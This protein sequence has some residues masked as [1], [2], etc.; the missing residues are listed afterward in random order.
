[1]SEPIDNFEHDDTDIQQDERASL[2]ARANLLGIK[3][4]PS[5][6]L[7]KLRERVNEVIRGN[8]PT[9]RPNPKE[10]IGAK[11]SRLKREATKLI[12]CR[13]HC[14]DPA[15][16]DWPGEVITVSNSVVG[17]I[18][19]YIPYNQDEPYHIPSILINAMRDKKCQVFVKKKDKHNN[20][21]TETK[22]ISAYTLDIL[23]PLTAEELKALSQA[24]L[25]RNSID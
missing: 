5:L 17:T 24:Q 2:E 6:S 16:K 13:I 14:N 23:P 25:A 22:L 12:R 19:K 20:Q 18:K 10:D 1:M 11:R 8:E 4:H 9:E 3:Y 7:E 21:I 15:K